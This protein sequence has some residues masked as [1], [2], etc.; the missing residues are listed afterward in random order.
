MQAHAWAALGKLGL[1]DEALAKK[2]IHLFVQQLERA[3]CPAVRLICA[4]APLDLGLYAA[5]RAG[6]LHKPAC[7]P[8]L[9]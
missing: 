2:C 9:A 3:I 8:S 6:A 7:T 1:A 5:E 4:Q